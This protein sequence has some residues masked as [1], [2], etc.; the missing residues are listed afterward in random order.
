LKV[1]KEIYKDSVLYCN[2]FD[3]IDIRDKL[4]KV[5]NNLI[6]KNN[7]IKKGFV[8]VKKYSLKFT[9]KKIIEIIEGLK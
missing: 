4:M 5:C 3:I 1:F 7:F 9:N 8:N 6:D 2:P